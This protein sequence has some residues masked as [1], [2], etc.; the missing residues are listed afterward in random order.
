MEQME[1][2]QQYAR[3]QRMEQQLSPIERE[4]L[5]KNRNEILETNQLY[6]DSNFNDLEYS[7]P[8]FILL[9]NPLRFDLLS[10]AIADERLKLADEVV[11][12][13]GENKNNAVTIEFYNNIISSPDD[14]DE[15]DDQVNGHEN[16]RLFKSAF[17]FDG[18]IQRSEY[19]EEAKQ[20]QLQHD[21]H[22]QYRFNFTDE[23]E[24]KV[25]SYRTFTPDENHTQN[26]AP[27]II[28][29]RDSINEINRYIRSTIVQMQEKN[30]QIDNKEMIVAVYSMMIVS[31]RIPFPGKNMEDLIKIHK[32]MK[33]VIKYIHCEDDYN[34]FFWY[35]L[36]CV[37]MPDSK[38]KEIDRYSRI[39]EGKRL[40]FDFYNVN[41]EDKRD[42]LNQYSGFNWDDSLKVAEKVNIYINCYEY[43]E[44]NKE[45]SYKLFTN[46]PNPN[47]QPNIHIR[48][49]NILLLNDD[50]ANQHI[51]Y[52]ISV[53]KLLGIKICPIC[54]NYAIFAQDCNCHVKRQMETHMSS[55]VIT[56]PVLLKEKIS[57]QIKATRQVQRVQIIKTL[58]L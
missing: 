44:E 50:E 40:L 5:W 28:Y 36:T 13:D 19:I 14:C 7:N 11:N 12:F 9:T 46:Y 1:N 52:I 35:N 53:E 34:T 55:Q 26:H 15:F 49:Y 48:D 39:A 51:M 4:I 22:G 18:A 42:F 31:Y 33:Y 45:V 38:G 24:K 3:L 29:G 37:T 54:R 57:V 20:R 10:Q 16:G 30:E 43:D 32:N 27:T 8:E 58:K 21:H 25:I 56:K 47:P 17:D 2:E 41:K 23:N 6:S